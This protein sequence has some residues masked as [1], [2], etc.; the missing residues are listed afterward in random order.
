MVA[1]LSAASFGILFLL[2]LFFAVRH[3]YV[4]YVVAKLRFVAIVGLLI[5]CG[6]VDELDV[7]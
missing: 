7:L 3:T 4:F 1:A 6:S 2:C 5:I